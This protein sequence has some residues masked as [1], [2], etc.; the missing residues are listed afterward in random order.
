MKRLTR[1]RIITIVWSIFW[2]GL[3]LTVGFRSIYTW[4]VLAIGITLTGKELF[5]PTDYDEDK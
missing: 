1:D 5:F 4:L 2:I 3:L